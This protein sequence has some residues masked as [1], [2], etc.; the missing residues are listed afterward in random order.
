MPVTTW[1]PSLLLV[2]IL[3]IIENNYVFPYFLFAL[4]PSLLILVYVIKNYMGGAD[5][6]AI[7]LIGVSFPKYIYYPISLYTLLFSSLTVL[8]FCFY[9]FFK[10]YN[11]YVLKNSYIIQCPPHK[12]IYLFGLGSPKEKE[13]EKYDHNIILAIEY[14]NKI[15]CL[16]ESNTN[17]IFEQIKLSRIRYSK[18]WIS[19]EIPFI[20]FISFGFILSIIIDSIIL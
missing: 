16:N 13:C 6:L 10:N 20:P 8:I 19:A 17:N 5:F 18:I 7:F 9:R 2:F 12:L 15:V 1:I 3:N 14:N 11:V 4:I